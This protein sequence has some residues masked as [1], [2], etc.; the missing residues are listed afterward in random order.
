ML[1]HFQ[2][3]NKT[4]LEENKKKNENWLIMLKEFDKRD[5]VAPVLWH[6]M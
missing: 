2:D 6:G 3:V 1:L 5:S 4:R